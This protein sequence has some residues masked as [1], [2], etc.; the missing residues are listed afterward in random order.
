MLFFSFQICSQRTTTHRCFDSGGRSFKM[1]PSFDSWE[2]RGLISEVFGWR[3][4]CFAASLVYSFIP[5]TPFMPDCT[6][7]SKPQL[8]FIMTVNVIEY[9]IIFFGW[10]W[11]RIEWVLEMTERQLVLYCRSGSWENKETTSRDTTG[12]TYCRQ[13]GAT[14]VNQGMSHKLQQVPNIKPERHWL[15]APVFIIIRV[16]WVT[17]RRLTC[18]VAVTTD[19][20]CDLIL[21]D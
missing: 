6:I 20:Q 7:Q 16:I 14:A 17:L 15:D 8:L 5:A 2:L 19:S 18:G 12:C 3:R 10:M 21:T 4:R 11:L 9:I 1:Q 13:T